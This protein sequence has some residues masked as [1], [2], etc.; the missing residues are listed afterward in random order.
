MTDQLREELLALVDGG[1]YGNKP[2]D[3]Y[4][5]KTKLNASMDLYMEGGLSWE[6]AVY[7]NASALVFRDALNDVA[8]Y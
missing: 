5:A 6:T 2:F 7:G 1:D 4:R 3:I 8:R